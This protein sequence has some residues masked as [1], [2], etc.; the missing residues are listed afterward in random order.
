MKR[1]PTPSLKQVAAAAGVSIATASQVLRGTDESSPS[2]RKHVLEVAKRLRYRPNLLVRGMQTGQSFIVGLIIAS[3]DMFLATIARGVHDR[4]IQSNFVPIQLWVKGPRS[5]AGEEEL[6]QIH[7]LVDRRVDGVILWPSDDTVSD[8]YFRELWQRQVPLVT[9]DRQTMTHADHVGTDDECGGRLAAEH[10]LELGHRHVAQFAG[11]PKVVTYFK[12]RRAFSETIAAAG[13]TCLVRECDAA[14]N[15]TA[16]AQDILS[17]IGEITA[18]FAGD[19]VFATALSI[20]AAQSGVRVPDQLSIIGYADI[21][22]LRSIVPGLTTIHQDAHQTG[23]T[24]AQ[25]VLDRIQN[26]STTAEHKTILMRPR[27]VVRSSTSKVR[28]SGVE[29]RLSRD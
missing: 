7:R 18:V 4:L 20:A 12:R 29:V 24:A 3:D 23:T 26:P 14:E 21:A 10:L 9:V 15:V 5:E 16:V 1:V 19:D 27:L 6:A 25:L 8:L 28:P 13:G 22:L 2:T 11:N 17:H